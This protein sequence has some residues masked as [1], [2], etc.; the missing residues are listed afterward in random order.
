[1][2]RGIGESTGFV[3]SLI[4]R[5]REL[6]VV[7]ER[8]EAACAGSRQVVLIQGPAGIGKTSLLHAALAGAVPASATVLRS[9]CHEIDAGTPYGVVR[10]L[11]GPLGLTSPDASSAPVL[12]SGARWALPALLDAGGD[13]PSPDTSRTHSLLHGLYWLAVNL[14]TEAPLVLAVDDVQWADERSLHW[15]GYLLRRTEG[16]PL[17]VLLTAR[18]PTARPVTPLLGDVLTGDDGLLLTLPPLDGDGVSQVV[19]QESDGP[20][21]ADFLTACGRISGGNPLVLARLLGE[22]RRLGL[23]PTDEALPVLARIGRNVVGTLVAGWL[24]GQPEHVRR[25][26]RAVAVLERTDADLVAAL[27]GVPVH[28]AGAVLDLLRRNDILAEDGREVAH[29]LV[30]TSLLDDLRPPARD[31]L[32]DRAAR[33]LNDAGRPA[34]EVAA[35]LLLLPRPHEP[36]MLTALAAAAADA[37]RRGAPEAAIRYLTPLVDA[38]PRDVDLRLQLAALLGQTDPAAALEH[39]RTALETAEDLRAR[40]R[41]AVRFGMTALAVQRSPEAVEVLGEVLDALPAEL[42]ADCAA[43]DR[44][45]LTHVRSAFLIAGLDEKRTVPLVRE[46]VRAMAEPAGDTPAERQLLAMM[47]VA[48]ALAGESPAL[49]V[50]R[51]NRAVLLDDGA[52]GGWTALASTF[53]LD[54][55]GEVPAGLVAVDKLLT[56]SR[57][58]A[59]VWS[60][61]LALGTRAV[62]LRN[63]GD[64]VESGAD[65]Q[66]AL[67]IAEQESWHGNVVQPVVEVAISLA[68]RGSPARAEGALSRLVRPRMDD[69]VVENH[70]YRMARALVRSHLGDVEGAL[71]ELRRCGRSLAEAGVA[72]PLF[73]PWWAEAA[74]LLAD[75]GRADEAVELVEHGEQLVRGWDVPRARGLALLARAAVDRAEAVELLEEAVR[76]LE[77]SSARYDHQRAEQRL[78]WELLCRGDARAA[79]EHLRRAVDL[80]TRCGSAVAA[81]RARELLVRAGGRMRPITGARVD[82]LTGSERRVAMMA[83]AGST[84][85]EIAETLFVTLRTVEVHL[86]SV[87]RKLGVCGRAELPAALARERCDLPR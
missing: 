48:G 55:A 70:H 39:L 45:L 54:L 34:E 78:G 7:K 37:R 20:P 23:R 2:P 25:V 67:E 43:A 82:T 61:C 5:A 79:R 4:G 38:E 46:R 24:A 17:C 49:A 75:A 8:L 73:V 28:T 83:V 13:G 86:S 36:W 76:V 50:E 80:A 3:D 72:N 30:R 66:V 31:R 12:R 41:A 77:G 15:L 19:H 56:R 14:M 58:H 53:V 18:A 62:L 35:Q 52:L 81:T 11:V 85:R 1:M 69:F 33:L 74:L 22:V 26:A 59:E 21:S 40:A 71:A 42:G 47:A 10:E 16:M 9:R 51:V 6:A 87:Y 60:Y 44:E 68:H 32:R 64:F 63:A 29:D 57:A 84:N 65:A 27:S